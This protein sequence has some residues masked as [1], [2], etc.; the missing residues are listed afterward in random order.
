MKHFLH[1]KKYIHTYII[2]IFLYVR[3]ESK[4]AKLSLKDNK[5]EDFSY[6]TSRYHKATVTLKM[7]FRL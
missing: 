6:Q 3:K 5:W 1:V 2:K 7:W 4:I